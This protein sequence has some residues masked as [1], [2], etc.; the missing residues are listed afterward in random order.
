MTRRALDPS[1][2]AACAIGIADRE[3]L[4]AVTMRRVAGELDVTA[5]ALYRHV[6]DRDGLLAAMGAA[7]ARERPLLPDGE[8]GWADMLRRMSQ[9]IWASFRAHP[10]LL[11]IVIAPGRLLDLA[12]RDR[13]ERLLE[14][15]E[16]GGLSAETA[17]DAVLGVSAASIGMA[18]IVFG[19]GADAVVAY[20][21]DAPEA[22][23]RPRTAALRA[24]GIGEASGAAALASTVEHLIAGLAAPA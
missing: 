20:P 9:S 22:S 21:S 7:V 5:M 23:A 15:L 16:A 3:G 12:G 1:A 11:G 18:D 6:G 17:V 13:T 19:P 14:A 24:R 8:A 2:I 4:E 10:W